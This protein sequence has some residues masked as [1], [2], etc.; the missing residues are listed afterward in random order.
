[1]QRGKERYSYFNKNI[2]R[3]TPVLRIEI[4][5]IIHKITN[6]IPFG[7]LS[8]R[9]RSALFFKLLLKFKANFALYKKNTPNKKLNKIGNKRL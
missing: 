6:T 4:P 1:M 9:S 8:K 7:K 3:P 5:N 2:V